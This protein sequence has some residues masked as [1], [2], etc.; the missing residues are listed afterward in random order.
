MSDDSSNLVANIRV[1]TDRASGQ[2]VQVADGYAAT[3][4]TLNLSDLPQA[5]S[6]VAPEGLNPG[7][8]YLNN[9]A[10]CCA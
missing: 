2:T 1:L 7:D 10:V 4:T 5:V 8:L 9:G 3:F 6:G